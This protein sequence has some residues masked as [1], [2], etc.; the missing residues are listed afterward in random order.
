V[1]GRGATLDPLTFTLSDS[2]IFGGRIP[3]LHGTVRIAD[4][5]VR[6]SANGQ[7]VDLAPASCSRTGT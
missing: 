3:E 4:K 6:F 1:T 5:Q 2:R 7:F